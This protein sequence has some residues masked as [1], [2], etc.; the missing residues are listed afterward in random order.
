MAVCNLALSRAQVLASLDVKIPDYLWTPNS[1][2]Y[3]EFLIPVAETVSGIPTSRI[4][5]P[6]IL[7]SRGGI[8][9]RPGATA[10]GKLG[11]ASEKKNR[12][13]LASP[14]GI[15]TGNPWVYCLLS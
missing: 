7:N 4:R 13:S 14:A 1:G 3:V 5:I 15:R 6:G 10:G 11:D 12:L 9:G 8:S 2:N